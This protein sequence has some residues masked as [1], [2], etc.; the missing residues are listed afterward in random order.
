VEL[1]NVGNTFNIHAE[2][3]ACAVLI[4]LIVPCSNLFF[5]L[6]PDNTKVLA[7]LEMFVVNERS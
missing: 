4:G 6:I 5:Y 3:A 2:T 1:R 7:G